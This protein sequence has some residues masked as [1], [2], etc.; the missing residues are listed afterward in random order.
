MSFANNQKD[1]RYIK[2]PHVYNEYTTN[3]LLVYSYIDGIPIDAIK[4]LKY[5]GYDLDEIALKMADNCRKMD[6]R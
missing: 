6:L 1:I 2:A 3:H 4:R 5:E